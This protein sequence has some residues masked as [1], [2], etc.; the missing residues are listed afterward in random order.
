MTPHEIFVLTIIALNLPL[1]FSVWMA[2]FR[3]APNRQFFVFC[4]SLSLWIAALF[5]A[6]RSTSVETAKWMIRACFAT[7]VLVP[8]AGLLLVDSLQSRPLGFLQLLVRR[9]LTLLT[10]LTLASL[11]LSPWLLSS[12]TI[13]PDGIPEPQFSPL[14]LLI[15]GFHLVMWGYII[16]RSLRVIRDFDDEVAR[17]EA[18]YV[19]TGACTVY[20]VG[21]A[22]SLVLPM[23]QGNSQI[24]AVAPFTVLVLTAVVAFGISTRSLLS[25]SVFVR[26]CTS[27]TLLS[28]FLASVYWVSWTAAKSLAGLLEWDPVHFPHVFAAGVSLVAF[29]QLHAILQR[30][31]ETAFAHMLRGMRFDAKNLLQ[32]ADREFST[33]Q[34]NE[35]LFQRLAKY[36]SE[37]AGTDDIDFQFADSSHNNHPNDPRPQKLR[38]NSLNAWLRDKKKPLVL[39]LASR[40]GD[41]PQ[42][43]E[44]A[45]DLKS[46]GYAMAVGVRSNQRYLGTILVGRRLYGRSYENERLEAVQMLANQFGKA[47]ENAE[48]YSKVQNDRIYSVTLLDNLVSGVVA[49]DREG[50]ITV[51]NQEAARVLGVDGNDKS[52]AIEDLPSPV[53]ELLL[54]TLEGGSRERD[55]EAE[56]DHGEDVIVARLG[57][58]VFSSEAGERLGA[59]AVIHDVTLEK[60]LEGLIRNQKKSAIV[61]EIAAHLAHEIR[62][63]LTAIKTFAQILPERRSD[64]A[65]IDKFSGIVHEEVNR[66]NG[67]IGNLLNYAKPKEESFEELAVHP[68]IE[69][70]SEL[71]RADFKKSK[72]TLITELRAENDTIIG[73]SD[74]LR[75]IL[76]NLL[77]NAKE[78]MEG[79]RG[80]IHIVSDLIDRVESREKDLQL[81]IR[82]NGKGM[83]SEI[84]ERVFDPFFTTKKS[85]T[86]IGLALTNSLVTK[87][88]GDI[89]V[90]SSPGA[91]TIF[92]IHFPVAD[93]QNISL[94]S[95][96]WSSP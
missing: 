44:A 91:G 84:I 49:V 42:L 22:F 10:T 96:S 67:I 70:V 33:F 9:P 40:M 51:I 3:Q 81:T 25:V 69:S 88:Q 82:D 35:D 89:S 75:Q 83:P 58:A 57:G 11:A 27:V 60:Q 39:S 87:Q 56:L 24:V 26:R 48:L 17:V 61:G 66:I 19:A 79:K 18:Q 72:V 21:L 52:V 86:G 32:Q 62:N 12:A 90:E 13:Q 28:V 77:L 29:A 94:S 20:P 95:G 73:N 37:A 65:F 2:N 71:L 47:L 43:G 16:A 41:D 54:R 63:P 53:S 64:N 23:L 76:I 68:V 6:F 59:L 45:A 85:G 8:M 92:T 50:N 5:F 7:G 1:G 78:A 55:L 80:E 15:V 4:V 46:S 93:S 34:T 38:L 36:I 30:F 14:V 74:Y 31:V